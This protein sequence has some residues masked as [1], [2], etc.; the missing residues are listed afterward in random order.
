VFLF[1]YEL[2]GQISS[3][4]WDVLLEN[5]LIY[6][7][8]KAILMK[9]QYEDGTR[10]AS[11]VVLH[12]AGRVVRDT[13]VAAK[14]PNNVIKGLVDRLVKVREMQQQIGDT[15]KLPMPFQYF[16]LL[17]MM[18][19]VNLMLWAYGM[20][21]TESMFSPIGFFFAELIFCGMMELAG[22]MSDPFGHDEVDFPLHIWLAHALWDTSVVLEYEYTIGAGG[23]EEVAAKFPALDMKPRIVS[24]VMVT[25]TRKEHVHF[26]EH[27]HFKEGSMSLVARCCRPDK[28]DTVVAVY[29]PIVVSPVRTRSGYTEETDTE[30][31][32]S[33]SRRALM[34]QTPRDD[35]SQ[36]L[37][38]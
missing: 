38:L 36:P 25:Q 9:F 14:A 8:E 35:W 33:S 20:G 13:V 27:A 34:S 6:P 23:W 10:H 15:M 3:D 7:E 11:M 4:E 31:P 1:F 28:N 37:S 24:E 26:K 30:D 18:V 2:N 5:Q 17:N 21:V 16:H 32:P 12:W 19:V 29:Q 22:Q